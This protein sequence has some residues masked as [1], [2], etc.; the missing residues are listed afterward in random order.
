MAAPTST[1]DPGTDDDT[2]PLV[3]AR[4][5]RDDAASD[6]PTTDVELV[7]L[8]DDTTDGERHTVCPAESDATDLVTTWL[9]VDATVVCD[10]QDW[11]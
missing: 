10:L 9:T 7:T 1:P 2:D 8:V 4:R 11:R 5:S 3:Q 6:P